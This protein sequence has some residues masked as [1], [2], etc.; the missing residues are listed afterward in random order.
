MSIWFA[1]P[2]MWLGSETQTGAAHHVPPLLQHGCLPPRKEGD[3]FMS[4]RLV[5]NAWMQGALKR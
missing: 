2:D 1:E 5:K 3:L 4:L